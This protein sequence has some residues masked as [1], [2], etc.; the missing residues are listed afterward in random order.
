MES[1]SK[2]V[3]HDIK[4]IGNVDEMIRN[5]SPVRFKYN[6]DK[7]NRERLGLI[8]EDTVDVMPELCREN[9]DGDKTICYTEL[10]PALLK[11]IQDMRAEIDKLKAIA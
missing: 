3:K 6:N 9:K 4:P 2:K 7:E 5:L 11:E 8:W 10:I 1:S